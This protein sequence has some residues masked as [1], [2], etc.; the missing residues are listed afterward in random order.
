[1]GLLQVEHSTEVDRSSEAGEE[2][3][4]TVTSAEGIVFDGDAKDD[5]ESSCEEFARAL[6]IEESN[7]LAVD[8]IEERDFIHALD[9]A[10]GNR[11]GRCQQ[12]F[13]S[14]EACENGCDLGL[15]IGTD[16]VHHRLETR[17]FVPKIIRLAQVQTDLGFLRIR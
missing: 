5:T 11:N 2:T 8:G 13:D 4:S 16:I 17:I 7:C 10:R 3:V 6:R 9:A 14:D 15:G 12:S 1:M